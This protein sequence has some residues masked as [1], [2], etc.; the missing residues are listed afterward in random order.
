[1]RAVLSLGGDGDARLR[2]RSRALRSS[3]ITAR[4][5]APSRTKR[6]QEGAVALTSKSATAESSPAV[7][8]ARR[9]SGRRPRHGATA[10]GSLELAR[11]PLRSPSGR[12]TRGAAAGASLLQPPPHQR[13]PCPSLLALPQLVRA[14]Y[15]CDA[16]GRRRAADDVQPVG[17]HG[18]GSHIALVRRRAPAQR[19]LTW[20]SF[21]SARR[22]LCRGLVPAPT[23]AGARPDHKV[24]AVGQH[25]DDPARRRLTWR[26]ARASR[27]SSTASRCRRPSSSRSG[28]GGRQHRQRVDV[29]RGPGASSFVVKTHYARS[30]PLD[31]LVPAPVMSLRRRTPPRRRIPRRWPS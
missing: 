19:P 5:G 17:G 20:Y 6:R 3:G 14:V 13:C 2:K 25:R 27:R 15:R 22:R 31:G 16:V 26:C 18:D 12:S 7:E 4:S 28:G 10:C 29:V 23:T 24:R 8:R 30:P 9:L 1:M 11:V 21:S